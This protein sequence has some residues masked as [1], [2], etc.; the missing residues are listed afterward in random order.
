MGVAIIRL[1]G[2]L[3]ME[4][5]V[6]VKNMIAALMAEGCVQV[7]VDFERVQHI[8]ATGLGIL[9][10][11][12]RCVRLSGGDL[13]LAGLNPCL[14][15]IFELTGVKRSFRSFGTAEEAARSFASVVAAA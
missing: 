13:R 2:D 3:D 15:S 1:L 9:V 8:N 14:Q 7:V 12:L 5:M 6:R 4:D 10:E 11:R